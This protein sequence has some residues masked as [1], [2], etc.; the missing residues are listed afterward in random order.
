MTAQPVV[1]MIEP[2]PTGTAGLDHIR[3]GG[4]PLGRTTLVSGPA[5]SGKTV[6]GLQLLAQGLRVFDEPAV[7]VT[8][9]ERPEVIRQNARSLGFEISDFEQDGTWAFVDAAYDPALEEEVVGPHDFVA[10][11]GNPRHVASSG[12]DD[13]APMFGQPE[14]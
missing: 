11:P 3:R 9:E 10:L 4:M 5:G 12:L 13:I 1:S 14:L 2:I 6:L 7:F 8:F